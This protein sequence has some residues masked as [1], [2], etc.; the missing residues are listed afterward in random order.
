ML[1]ARA[2]V[3]IGVDAGDAEAKDSRMELSAHALHEDAATALCRGRRG[4]RESLRR[5]D[6]RDHGYVL[7][8][9]GRRPSSGRA[10]GREAPR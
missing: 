5:L 6:E 4:T 3:A 9:G 1:P 2:V 8:S 7:A 10:V